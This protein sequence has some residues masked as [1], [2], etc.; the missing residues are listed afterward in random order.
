MIMTVCIYRSCV[1]SESRVDIIR[2]LSAQAAAYWRIIV[3]L[4]SDCLTS[5]GK[6]L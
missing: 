5:T 3:Q 1:E 4:L 2:V 6:Y